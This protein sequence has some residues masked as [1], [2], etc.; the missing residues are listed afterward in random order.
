[1]YCLG[2]SLEIEDEP[3]L[4][5]PPYA[6]AL[7]AYTRWRTSDKQFPGVPKTSL[8]FQ[9]T[10]KISDFIAP[11]KVQ[12][13]EGSRFIETEALRKI[14]NLTATLE[15]ERKNLFVLNTPIGGVSYSVWNK[16][17]LCSVGCSLCIIIWFWVHNHK[18]IKRHHGKLMKSIKIHLDKSVYPELPMT[19]NELEEHENRIIKFINSQ[20]TTN[21]ANKSTSPQAAAP[22]VM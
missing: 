5:C 9:V 16:I 13:P 1:M 11:G 10:E 15:E 19:Q 4:D 21:A 6:I 2:R 20:P 17:L 14:F 3:P 12:D 7:P 8:S 18:T 22:R